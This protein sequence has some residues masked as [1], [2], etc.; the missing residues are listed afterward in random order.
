MELT[1]YSLRYAAASGSSS[2]LA[3]PTSSQAE[4]RSEGSGFCTARGAG[5]DSNPQSS[6]LPRQ[7]PDGGMCARGGCVSR[8]A[9][10]S[11]CVHGNCQVHM[12]A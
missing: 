12:R 9:A 11:S 2:C 10:S 1:A 8:T 4:R 6:A 5:Q 3:L 7:Y